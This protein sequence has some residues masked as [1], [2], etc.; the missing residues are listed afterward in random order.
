MAKRSRSPSC[1]TA[2]PFAIEE[3]AP[4]PS[5]G[6]LCGHHVLVPLDPGS[7][8]DCIRR[9]RCFGSEVESPLSKWIFSLEEALFL[10]SELSILS[11]CDASGMVLSVQ[12][13]FGQC[14]A[15]VPRFSWRF[16][17]YRHYRLAGWV[18]R[19]DSLKFGADF[20]LYDGAPSEV[21]A[22]YA[23]LLGDQQLLWKEAIMASRLAQLVAKELLVVFQ[24]EEGE[25]TL[26]ST[27]SRRILALTVR[28][29]QHHLGS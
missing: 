29:W 28:P 7:E 4:T 22:R 19:P 12:D 25:T 11:I 26:E 18:V 21:H 27:C 20:L 13:F 23:V 2:D 8:L 3:V 17:A 6:S 14:C 16:A 15:V 24:P 9:Q 1:N 5:I 10:Q